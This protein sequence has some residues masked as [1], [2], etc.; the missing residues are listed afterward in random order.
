MLIGLVVRAAR[1]MRDASRQYFDHE[2]EAQAAW[3]GLN[4]A[5][6]VLDDFSAQTL[7]RPNDIP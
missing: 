7:R 2:P 4:E 3:D 5:L 1:N 6:T